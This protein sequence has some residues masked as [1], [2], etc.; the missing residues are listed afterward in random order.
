VRSA[1]LGPLNTQNAVEEVLWSAKIPSRVK[2]R[3]ERPEFRRGW[4]DERSVESAIRVPS[5]SMS[6]S[7]FRR[8]VRTVLSVTGDVARFAS[9]ALQSRASLAAENLFLRK[10]LAL[11]LERQVKP[12]RADDAIRITLVALSRLVNWRRLL[13]V[14]KPDTMIRWHRQGIRL[15]WRRK[16]KPSGRPR[17]PAA[18]QRLIVEM[19]TAN[20]TWSEK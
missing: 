12:R 18:V 2:I 19:A 17:I 11:Y 9:L 3:H 20:R 5:W 8:T 4:R 13:V 15:F 10:Q 6:H 7:A 1:T 14:V 16:S